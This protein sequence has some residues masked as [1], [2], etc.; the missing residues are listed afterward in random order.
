[1]SFSRLNDTL[2]KS[3]TPTFDP[4]VELCMGHILREPLVAILTSDGGDGSSSS[5]S[6]SNRLLLRKIT[7]QSYTG[8]DPV[9]LRVCVC[10]CVN[11]EGRGGGATGL[12]DGFFL[13][14][15]ARIKKKKR[16]LLRNGM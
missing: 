5:S 13:G 10:V 3:A 16:A 9:G 8:N 12:P 11:G 2:C 15:D 4:R 1:M 7:R 14:L 6:S